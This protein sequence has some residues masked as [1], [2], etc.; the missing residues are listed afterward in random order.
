[1]PRIVRGLGDEVVYHVINRGN[2]RQEV[3]H[4]EGDYEAFM[5][6]MK[7]AKGRYPVKLYG[8]CL[9]PNHFHMAVR[10]QR[11][12]G[13]SKW[14]QWLMTSHVRRYHRHYESSGHVWQGRYKS[15]MI[16]E[17]S[18][19]LMALRYIEGNP[20]RAKIVESAR[21]W[22]WS[23]H[24]ETVG[25]EGRDLTDKAPIELP[26]E[27]TRYVDEPFGES[28]LDRLRLSVNRQT[29]FGEATWQ[30][31]IC[32]VFGLKSTMVKRGRPKKEAQG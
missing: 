31:K 30:M 18:H 6:L 24:K 26:K 16:Q 32:E 28:E 21:Q 25:E 14:M 19:L 29:P 9:M 13:L 10:P 1:M 23:S 12:E 8:Y 3:F 4:K 27:W 22:R 2:G 20:V 15:F 11:G 17:D 5:E 7:E